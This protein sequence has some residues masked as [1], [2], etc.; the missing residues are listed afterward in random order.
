[1]V[2]AFERSSFLGCSIEPDP[3][4]VEASTSS[5]LIRGHAYSITDLRFLDI[6]TPRVTGKIPLLRIRNPWGNEVEWNGAWSDGSKEW[7]CIDD[8]MKEEIGLVF[9]ADGEFW[10]TFKDFSTHFDRLEFCNL[11]PDCLTEECYEDDKRK[12]KLKVFDGAWSGYSAGGCRNYLETFANNPQYTIDLDDVDE[13]GRCTVIVALMQKNRRA[14]RKHGVDCLTIGFAMYKLNGSEEHPLSSEF[15]KFNASCARSPT[16][17]NLREVSCRFK[18]DPGSY[19]IV[20][21]TFEPNQE[22]EFIIRVFTE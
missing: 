5:G 15:F 14:R 6:E 8:D 20:P 9:D 4:V 17:I 16:F 21:S 3:N 11:S 22:G 18:L 7:N 19:A 2:K 13:D 1:M 10:M 12:W